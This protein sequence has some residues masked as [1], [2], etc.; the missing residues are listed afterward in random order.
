MS[1]VLMVGIN[2][3]F[4]HRN[5]AIYSIGEYCK[6]N[7]LDNIHYKEYSINNNIDN[8]I[9]S[10]YDQNADVIAFSCY[11]WN[12][13]IIKQII[14][15][16]KSILPNS[17]IVLGGPEVSFEVKQNFIDGV[18][19]YIMGEGE[20]SFYKLCKYLDDGYNISDIKGIAYESNG[21]IIIQEGVE[22][23]EL[24]EI[25]FVY[26]DFNED[27][28][29]I[30]Y[31]ASRGCPYS[32][33]YCLSS[34]IKG[35]RFLS[36]ERVFDDLQKFLDKKVK[37]VKFV[38]R[39]FNIKKDFAVKIWKFLI[40]NDNG[41]TNFH[42]ELS[43]DILTDELLKVTKK[44]RVG[45]FQFEIG[46]QS[47]NEKTLSAISRSHNVQKIFDNVNKVMSLENIHVHLDLIIGLPYE[48]FDSFRKSFNDV[49]NLLPHQLQVGFLKVLKG[50]GIKYQAEDYG[51]VYRGFAPYE[52][53]KTNWLSYSEYSKLKN[54]EELV[55]IY[56]NSGLLYHTLKYY[57]NI[58]ND[59][60]SFYYGFAKYFKKNGYF[61]LAHKRV[62]LYEIFVQF[63]KEQ[64]LDYEAELMELVKLDFLF[65]EKHNNIPI[66]IGEVCKQTVW[67]KLN[68]ENNELKQQQ[69]NELIELGFTSKQI[70]RNVVATTFKYD[71]QKLITGEKE[72]RETTYFFDYLKPNEHTKALGFGNCNYYEVGR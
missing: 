6:T 40:Q 30:Y 33:Q 37:Q 54:I 27:N 18:D 71:I 56:Y 46:V 25:P 39:T 50:S 21:E 49:H 59:Y 45:L 16:I 10:I 52:V 47:T 70:A 20:V 14:P 7:G 32:C 65:N 26:D 35:V 66:S 72:E 61:D 15:I 5:L 57:K 68:E 9:N 4:I 62:A 13:E 64:Y 8:I 53:Y 19:Y 1:K 36:E 51:I 38:D 3:K 34:S 24:D 2:A 58:S 41:Y 22:V 48:D 17:K 31:E 12:Y 69:F 28:R 11:I 60:F 43:A 42:F 63:I 67:D 55:E 23:C 29:I 44:A